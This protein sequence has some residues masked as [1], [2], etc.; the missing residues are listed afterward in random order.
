MLE[1]LAIDSR[2]S[3]R[4]AGEVAVRQG[5][6]GGQ[7][8]ARSLAG[9]PLEGCQ[10]HGFP[11]GS[12][13]WSGS[14]DRSGGKSRKAKA[15]GMA[16]S[17]LREG[18]GAKSTKGGSTEAEASTPEAHARALVEAWDKAQEAKM[19]RDSLLLQLRQLTAT[20]A[21]ADALRE[22]LAAVRAQLT[23][24]E[25][26]R[27]Q[28]LAEQQLMEDLKESQRSAVALVERQVGSLQAQLAHKEQARRE[29]SDAAEAAERQVQALREEAMRLRAEDAPRVAAA[30]QAAEEAVAARL[31][32]AESQAAQQVAEERARK[33]KELSSRMA[34]S[35]KER[36]DELRT[37]QQRVDHK[38]ALLLRVEADNVRLSRE[39]Q[40]LARARTGAGSRGSRS[41]EVAKK[42][43]DLDAIG[44]SCAPHPPCRPH[45]P[46]C[47]ALSAPAGLDLRNLLAR[48]W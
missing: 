2:Q 22:E 30:K 5:E 1:L 14:V 32:L 3:M 18:K 38:E 45:R 13:E 20:A 31:A 29:L 9:A 46:A 21:D 36:Q 41:E 33:A 44:L 23:D 40:E 11:A 7:E 12:G 42:I 26:A 10:G 19:E 27:D 37:A 39:L 24:T 28:A 6:G 16:G 25:A 48:L 8:G 4:G 35:L 15:K 34:R 17:S 43:T 47:W